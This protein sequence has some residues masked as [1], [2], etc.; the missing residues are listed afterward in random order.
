MPVP[1]EDLPVLLPEDAEFLPTGQ[2][3]LILDERF[4]NTTCPGCGG[5]ARRETDT[6]DTFVDSSWYFLRYPDPHYEAGPFNP[7]KVRYWLPV[8]MYCGGIEHAILHLLYSRFFTKA[9]RDMGLLEFG[10]PFRKLFNQGIILGPDHE[11][12]SKSR[13]NVVTPD[14]YLP[15]HGA[16]CIRMFL[17]FMGPWD[18]GGPWNDKGIEGIWRFLNRIWGLVLDPPAT[19]LAPHTPDDERALRRAT[20]QTIRTVTEQIASFR[21]NT[22]VATL[23]TFENHLGRAQRTTLRTTPAWDEAIDALLRLLAPS[24]PH[25]AEELWARLGKP[26]SIHNQSWPTWDERLAAEDQIEYAVQVNGKVRDRITLPADAAPEQVQARALA[27]ER[28]QTFLAGKAPRKVM[29]V[30]RRLVSI[31]V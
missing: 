22:M 12:M 4:V 6:M 3:P 25:L 19:K 7:E 28:V 26:Y 24:A 13:G 30:P 11:K 9:L 16:D 2:S 29:V 15:T 23:M 8:D 31:S 5:P 20:H 10:E 18:R 14:D 1:E 17:M 27:S 21:Y